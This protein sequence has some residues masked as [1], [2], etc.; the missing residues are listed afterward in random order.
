MPRERIKMKFQDEVDV[1]PTE[2]LAQKGFTVTKDELASSQA[3]S[4]DSDHHRP[5]LW[6]AL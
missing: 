1:F 4:I 6:Y 2:K 5:A 3:Y